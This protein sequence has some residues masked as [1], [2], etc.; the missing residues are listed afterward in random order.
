MITSDNPLAV[1]PTRMYERFSDAARGIVDARI[2]QGIHFR[3]ADTAA[4]KQGRQV[5]K[6]AFKHFLRPV[7]GDDEDG[8]DENDH[9]KDQGDDD[10]EDR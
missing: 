9:D 5:A 6:W 8:D 2:Y 4:R 10:R 1:S 3:F 7:D